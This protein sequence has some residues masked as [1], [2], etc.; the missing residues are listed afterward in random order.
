MGTVTEFLEKKLFLKVNREK[1]TA[2]I[3]TE[4]KFLGF[5]FVLSEKQRKCAQYFIKRHSRNSGTK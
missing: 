1:T 3:I 5:A 2:A 4:V